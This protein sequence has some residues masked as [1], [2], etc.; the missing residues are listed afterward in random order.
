MHVERRVGIFWDLRRTS[1]YSMPF[2]SLCWQAHLPLMQTWKTSM[3]MMMMTTIMRILSS[4]IFVRKF[5]CQYFYFCC[6]FQIFLLLQFFFIIHWL[7]FVV[8]RTPRYA[9]SPFRSNLWTSPP[10]SFSLPPW[11]ENMARALASRPDKVYCN[12]IKYD[13]RVKQYLDLSATEYSKSSTSSSNT[14]IWIIYV[15]LIYLKKY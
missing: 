7:W 13:V 5:V 3:M 11:Q 9:T 4:M 8:S 15:L 14:S 10:P 12:R 1:L 6:S 2:L